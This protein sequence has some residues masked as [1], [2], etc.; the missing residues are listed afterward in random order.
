MKTVRFAVIKEHVSQMIDALVALS[1][2]FQIELQPDDVWYFTV[3]SEV[4]RAASF[5]RHLVR[6]ASN[7]RQIA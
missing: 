1:C 6:E 5:P 2:L 7:G 4:V 3:K